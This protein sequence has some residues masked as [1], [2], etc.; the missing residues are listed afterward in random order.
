MS[1]PSK[2]HQKYPTRRA[3][4]IIGAIF[5]VVM[6]AVAVLIL[7]KTESSGDSTVDS[8]FQ[9]ADLIQTEPEQ[10]C[11]GLL[12]QGVGSYTGRFLEDG[13]E[14]QVTDV[15]MI[16]LKISESGICSLPKYH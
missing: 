3:L 11:D 9:K 16:Q 2:K 8:F 12:L 14:E 1:K 4:L 7:R 10:L 15:M 5:C 13:S 6:I